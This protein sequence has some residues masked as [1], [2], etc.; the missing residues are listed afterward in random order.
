MWRRVSR[1][2]LFVSDIVEIVHLATFSNCVEFQD[3]WHRFEVPKF[4]RD[5]NF[6]P[7]VR[8]IKCCQRLLE[9]LIFNIGRYFKNKL[10]VSRRKSWG[11][12]FISMDREKC[13]DS[14]NPRVESHFLVVLRL[15]S[16]KFF[17]KESFASTF[18]FKVFLEGKNCIL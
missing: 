18:F 16:L 13:W 3:G 17:R 5:L 9:L 11:S 8:E 6:A 14:E 12:I 1:W 2:N 10:K 7:F 15:F 4:K